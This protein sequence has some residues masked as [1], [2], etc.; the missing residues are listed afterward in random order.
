VLSHSWMTLFEPQFAFLGSQMWNERKNLGMFWSQRFFYSPDFLEKI[1]IIEWLSH[2]VWWTF[3]YS[4][5]YQFR[6]M[7]DLLDA[8]W[9]IN[10][11]RYHHAWSKLI[12]SVTKK[13]NDAPENK[14]PLYRH[15]LDRIKHI[16]T[17]DITDNDRHIK[18]KN[19]LIHYLVSIIHELY[20]HRKSQ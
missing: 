8:W 4:L 18:T 2:D 7:Y 9:S 1:L 12:Y 3:L 10:F 16:L 6:I 11:A 17:I 14:K 19:T 15:T 13:I 20:T 5:Y